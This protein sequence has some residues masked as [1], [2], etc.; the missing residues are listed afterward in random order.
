MGTGAG[1]GSAEWLWRNVSASISSI[2]NEAKRRTRVGCGIARHLPATVP[3]IKAPEE[4]CGPRAGREEGHL[5]A[6]ALAWWQ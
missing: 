2:L 1:F 4:V 3:S 6:K 5:L